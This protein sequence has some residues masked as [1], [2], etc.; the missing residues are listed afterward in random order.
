[1]RIELVKILFF[2]LHF[3]SFVLGKSIHESQSINAGNI[4][5]W[6]KIDGDNDQNPVLLFLHGG[7]G[8]SVMGYANRFTNELQKHFIVVQWDQRETGKTKSL[9]SSQEP[10]TV[11]L[12]ERDGV[13]VINYL[14]SKFHQDKIYLVGHSW[15]G[16]FALIMASKPP[17][18]LAAFF[19]AAPMIH[20]VESEKMALDKMKALAGQDNNKNAQA[21][22][23]EIKIPFENGTQLFYHRKWLYQLI[24]RQKAP[25]TKAYVE[26]WST[27]W[28][29]L[30][31]EASEV[32]F[33]EAAP[34]IKCPIYFLIGTKDF[35]TN[36]KLTENYFQKLKAEKK[37]LFWFTGSAHGLNLT[38]SKKFQQVIISTVGQVKN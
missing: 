15:G 12:F 18:L 4:L 29:P 24:N 25:F 6:V 34:E 17:D 2:L 27:T 1:M 28:L 31:N 19:A 20:Q 3:S 7:P 36:F 23:A 30:L 8:S 9:N 11:S 38:E 22:L 26:I 5:Q 14:R 37:E 35:Q 32:N 16:F 13:D 10:L 33:A 21:E